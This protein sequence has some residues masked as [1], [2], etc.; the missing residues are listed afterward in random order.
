MS[1]RATDS[2]AYT[3]GYRDGQRGGPY[4][5]PFDPGYFATQYKKGFDKGRR[6]HD[7]KTTGLQKMKRIVV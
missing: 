2:A 1:G 3:R 6:E 7:K 4:H 5:N